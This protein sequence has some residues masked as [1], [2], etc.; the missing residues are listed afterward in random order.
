[1]RLQQRF[2]VLTADVFFQY[3]SAAFPVVKL[4]VQRLMVHR[5]LVILWTQV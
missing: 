3:Q 4:I 5:D 2:Q 1:M